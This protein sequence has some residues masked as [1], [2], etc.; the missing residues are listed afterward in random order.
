MSGDLYDALEACIDALQRGEDIESCLARYP[1]LAVD[2]RP[3]LAAAVDAASLAVEAVPAEVAR[4]GKSRFLNAA[5]ELRERDA[6][7]TKR[8][9]APAALV[10]F[11]RSFLITLSTA[12]VAVLAFVFLG[13]VGLVYASSN[14][15][16]GDALYRVKISWE[17][18][19]LQFA[20]GQAREVLQDRYEQ[21][22]VDE[23]D[24]L[25]ER[26]RA[27]DVEF[28]G[29]VSAASPDRLVV[30]GITVFVTDQTQVE[31]NIA[32]DARV[33]VEGFTQKDGTIVSSEV[34]VLNSHGGG[35]DR[36]GDD[37]S[38]EGENSGGDSGT[39]TGTPDNSGEG[40]DGDS[41][42]ATPTPGEGSG[43][44]GSTPQPDTFDLEGRIT[45]LNNNS[46]VVG[47]VLIKLDGSTE[48]RGNLEEG[49]TVR[50][51]GIVSSNGSYVATRVEVLS[52]S[53][54]SGG[55]SATPTSTSSSG[56]GSG[57]SSGGDDG[58]GGGG[59]GGGGDGGGGSG[60]STATPTP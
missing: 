48:V 15:L 43:S 31:G 55:G 19:R 41:G 13:S 36:D 21:E 35:Q 16:P 37:N 44:G 1:R 23:V 3:L 39:S 11:R 50:A 59:S 29:V 14:S 49:V 54:D 5:A 33:K 32:V 34:K 4:R 22:R 2:L 57:G 25:L 51:R 42:N 7:G 52:T 6:R 12:T 47:G 18:L 30:S 26:G 10:R 38:G 46:I 56:G 17:D 28:T 58:S 24:E 53:G 27:E 8:A 20:K 9:A 60:S 45:Q 40:S